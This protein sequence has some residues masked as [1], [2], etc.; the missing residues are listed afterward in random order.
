VFSKSPAGQAFT[1]TVQL[2][3]LLEERLKRGGGGGGGGG[4]W[5][6]GGFAGARIPLWGGFLGGGLGR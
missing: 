2:G 3:W 6:G 5:G 4:G 1:L